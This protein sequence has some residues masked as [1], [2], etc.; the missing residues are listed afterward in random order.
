MKWS[1][2]QLKGL[3]GSVRKWKNIVDETGTDEGVENCPLC[4]LYY[5]K[6]CKG[7]PVSIA[8][9]KINCDGS[10]YWLF[11]TDGELYEHPDLAKAELMFLK[12][13]ILVGSK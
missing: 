4:K 5:D 12:A 10:P 1:K 8:T 6:N 3:R 13:L 9:G 2:E 11:D 7:C